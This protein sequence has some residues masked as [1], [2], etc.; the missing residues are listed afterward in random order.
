MSPL[1]D[2]AFNR[3]RSWGKLP[4]TTPQAAEMASMEPMP[5]ALG[6]GSHH[7]T[8]RPP[9][10]THWSLS[11]EAKWSRQP[12]GADKTNKTAC[13][14]GRVNP[15]QAAATAATSPPS[16]RAS[17][18]TKM[19]KNLHPIQGRRNSASTTKIS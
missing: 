6:S 13:I 17:R 16:F 19:R 12:Q 4:G 10:R 2:K 14:S 15:T 7:R 8:N 3:H 11:S 9:P 18:N 1:S 5:P